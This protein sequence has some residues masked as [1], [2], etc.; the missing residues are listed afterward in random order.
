ME[1]CTSHLLFTG[2]L[3]SK[4]LLHTRHGS[5]VE[6]TTE[7]RETS[8]SPHEA[9]ILVEGRGCQ[10]MKVANKFVTWCQEWRRAKKKKNRV[11]MHG[12]ERAW[13]HPVFTCS[14]TASHL[15]VQSLKPMLS[16]N[17]CKNLTPWSPPLHSLM[18]LFLFSC[19]WL[20]LFIFWIWFCW[21]LKTTDNFI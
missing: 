2:H 4:H 9:F 1:A 18:T 14:A 13:G 5:G 8:P 21:W 10:K 7:N 16:L 11:K 20:Y 6:E 3:L 15:W 12:E 17:L 19:R